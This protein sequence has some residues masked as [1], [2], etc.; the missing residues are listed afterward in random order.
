MR[1]IFAPEGLNFHSLLL[2]YWCSAVT[3]C[4]EKVTERAF[5]ASIMFSWLT[6]GSV[7]LSARKIC[8]MGRTNTACVF[9]A[10]DGRRSVELAVSSL[11]SRSVSR[12]GVV[13]ERR[14]WKHADKSVVRNDE[15]TTGNY[16]L[17]YF[18]N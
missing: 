11:T 5:E 17:L 9:C 16:R 12:A 18:E 13:G 8:R 7:I 15:T 14:Q 2:C 4:K 6:A 3:I 10:A 1:N